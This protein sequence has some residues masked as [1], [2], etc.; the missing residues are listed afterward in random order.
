MSQ[1]APAPVATD[2]LSG[3]LMRATTALVT[4]SI[5]SRVD[6]ASLIC[7]TAPAPTAKA[8]PRCGTL[9]LAT[10]VPRGGRV[11]ATGAVAAA[12][13][14]VTAGGAAADDVELMRVSVF[15]A[16][17]L[18]QTDV[19]EGEIA[20]GGASFAGRATRIGD[21]DLVPERRS[22]RVTVPVPASPTK[23]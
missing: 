4:G 13:E 8:P 6:V 19:P 11:R 21:P 18:T 10:T 9:I 22:I 3:T 16:K 14:A 1:T 23:R 7:H 17:L 2:S 20:K 12:L 15:E 5:R